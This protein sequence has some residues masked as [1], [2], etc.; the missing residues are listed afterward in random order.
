MGFTTSRAPAPELERAVEAIELACGERLAPGFESEFAPTAGAFIATLAAGLERG[1]IFLTDYGLARREYYAPSRDGGTL[2]CFYRHR[3]HPDPFVRIGLQ[4]L[5]A[6]VDFTR[7]AESA[8][9]SGLEIAGF[10]TQAQFLIDLDFEG[11]LARLLAH[12]QGL[13]QHEAT[14]AAL[15]LVLPGEMGERFK[16]I[17]FSRGVEVSRG[18]RTRDLS[19]RL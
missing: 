15:T 9:A 8:L 14:Q 19:S 11:A 5:T 7:L 1:A 17:A 13:A 12:K 4:D 10:T 2:A 18:F 3:V 6:W 16:C